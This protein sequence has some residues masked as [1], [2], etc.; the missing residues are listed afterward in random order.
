MKTYKTNLPQIT[1]KLK[2]GETLN[3]Q[4]K[5]SE[6]S[7]EMFRKI[8]DNDTLP[9]YE[10]VICLFLNRCNNTIG[11][12]K[13]SQGGLSGSVIDNRI[14]LATALG[15]LASGIILAHNHPSGNVQPSEADVKVTEKLAAAANI[16]DITVLDHVIISEDNY[17]SFADNSKV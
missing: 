4:I 17:Y 10:S 14:I 6:D 1:L 7:V 12:F 5:T 11:W 9:I 3:C 13:V 2:K 15:C 8:W 16:M